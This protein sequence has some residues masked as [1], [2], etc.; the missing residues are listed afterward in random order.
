ML[1]YLC[2]SSFDS[3][4]VAEGMRNRFSLLP[5]KKTNGQTSI[6]NE[7][8]E[9]GITDHGSGCQI[10]ERVFSFESHLGSCIWKLEQSCQEQTGAPHP[11]AE[12]NLGWG[13]GSYVSHGRI[14]SKCWK[15]GQPTLKAKV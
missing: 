5:W 12:I 1:P 2:G 9:A 6:S 15:C 3:W 14:P 4:E 10:D 8:H 7:A 11:T 13:R